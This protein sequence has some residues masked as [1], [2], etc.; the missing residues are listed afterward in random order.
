MKKVAIGV[1]IIC[2]VLGFIAGNVMVKQQAVA[3]KADFKSATKVENQVPAKATCPMANGGACHKA[4]G[5][6]CPMAKDNNCSGMNG[7]SCGC[8]CSR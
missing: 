4:N 6:E 7:G 5:G 2:L 3:V 8:G 1:G